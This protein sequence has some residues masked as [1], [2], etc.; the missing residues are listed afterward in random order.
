VDTWLTLNEPIGYAMGAYIEGSYPPGKKKEF[1][2]CGRVSYHFLLAHN[3]SYDALHKIA[4]EQGIEIKVGIAKIFNP[5]QAYTWYNLLDA[6]IAYYMNYLL[7]DSMIDYYRTGHFNWCSK[8]PNGVQEYDADAPNKIDFI[9]VNYYSHTLI[10]WFKSRTRANEIP[11]DTDPKK[12]PKVIYAE[13]FYE[14]I[15][16]AAKLGKP[17]WITENGF[18]TEDVEKRTTFFGYH[19][20]ALNKAMED[21]PNLVIPSYLF[22]TLVDGYEWNVGRSNYGMFTHDRVMKPSIEYFK[23]LMAWATTA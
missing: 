6:S 10:G 15:N 5:I 12:H 11:S 17:V 4:N 3:A 21:N 2:T 18:A 7:N 8:L 16:K 14:A 1:C 23:N 22:W 20:Y 13:G 19:M 9:G